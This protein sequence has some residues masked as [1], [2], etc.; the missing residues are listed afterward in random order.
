M[1][2]W[3]TPSFFK[4]TNN[5]YYIF[6]PE[7]SAK[8]AG[9]RALHYLCHALN[10]LGKEAYI[11]G[12]STESA[13]LRSPLLRESDVVRH[14]LMNLLP[15]MV[16]PEVVKDNPLQMPFVVRWLLNQAGHLGGDVEFDELE[17]LFTYSNSYISEGL[18]APL[19]NI[20]LVN[21]A[22]FNNEDNADDNNRQG[23]CYYAHKYLAKGYKLTEHVV[24]STSL[25]QD[26]DIS[27][28]EIANILRR[29]ELLY[30]YEPSAII[31]E[32][33]LCGC[34]VIMID[35]PFLDENL[36][37]PIKGKGL[38]STNIPNAISEAKKTIGEVTYNDK[39]SIN[40]CWWQVDRF[41]RQTQ[42]VAIDRQQNNRLLNHD[43]VPEV[44]DF[45]NHTNGDTFV[46]S[47]KRRNSN[48][49]RW[50]KQN[51]LLEGE[52]VI[53]AE[54]M[55]NNWQ[56]KPT[57]H[58]IMVINRHELG[59]LSDTL[60]SL[61]EQLYNAWGLTIFSN[62]PQ[63][64]VVKDIPEN[65][66]WIEITD[67]LNLAINQSVSENALDWILQL[68]PGDKLASHA[69]LSFAETIN[70]NAETRFIYSDEVADERSSRLLFKPDFNLELLCSSSYLG[71]SVII[72]RD[73]F[74]AI[75]GYTGLA[76][77]YVTD[78]AFNIYEVW[79]ANAIAHIADVLYIASSVDVDDEVL[80]DSE[81]SVRVAHFQRQKVAA[82]I[83]LLAGKNTFTVRYL[84]IQEPLVSIIVANKNHAS[85]IWQCIDE[86]LT[87]TDYPNYEL[88]IVD[89]HSDIEDMEF[90]YQDM[91]DE[92]GDR[93]TLLSYAEPN[94]AAMINFGVS[95]AKGDY[96]VI[97]ANSA[98]PVN[99][100]WLTTMHSLSQRP[101]VGV[102]GVR[103]IGA[104]NKVVHA[105]GVLGLTDDVQGL[106]FGEEF[107]EAGYMGRAQ[108]TQEYS[109]VSSACFMV[110]THDYKSVGGLDEGDLANT[111]YS[112]AD[113][114]LK[115][116]QQGR[117]T[118]WEPQAVFRQ[119]MDMA[120]E[121]NGV[122]GEYKI[123]VEAIVIKRWPDECQ[124]DV[125]Y[126]RNLSLR[127]FDF[128]ADTVINLGW[129]HQHMNRPRI[130]AFPF[131]QGAIGHYRVI[132]PLR[133]LTH[134]AMIESTLLP[135]HDASSDTFIPNRF[136]MNKSRP[137]VLFMHLTLND[138][139]YEFLKRIK[140]ET[141][142][143]VVF[144]IDDLV[145]SL[146]SKNA[147]K[148]KLHKDMRH[149]LGRTLALCDR[150]VASTQPLADALSLYC[151]D[152]KIIPNCIDLARWETIEAQPQ[153]SKKLRVG[154]A[155]GQYHSGDLDIISDVVKE[156][157]AE[158]D[159]IFMGMCPEELKPYIHEYH[160]FSSFHDYPE[161]LANLQLDLAVAPLEVHPFNE[162]KSN[163]R[164][165]EYGMLAWP[166]ICSDIYPY[167]TNN[168]PVTRIN[169]SSADWLDAIRAAIAHP[170]SLQREGQALRSWVLNNYVLEQHREKWLKALTTKV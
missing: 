96:V 160:D 32:A 51:I 77:V 107:D 137:D 22:L 83:A 158:I 73:A 75:G 121:S 138:E 119:N 30:C 2:Q 67:T 110:S 18:S 130:M 36:S 25:C 114:C 132:E 123:D 57:F 111:K 145:T 11:I 113:L 16:Y 19:L 3:H 151:E 101:E 17:L 58:L 21:G 143:F 129:A 136:E 134:A 93:F 70:Q 154:W 91:Q 139:F 37:S 152:I 141:T 97:L 142:I 10:E 55:L 88:V 127:T 125:F 62:I 133:E 135:S 109:F 60:N 5:P 41:I 94:Y 87:H 42:A 9:V 140:A 103:V 20:P 6:A 153:T 72:R 116:K 47:K 124:N 99:N 104:D 120:N 35:T 44:L 105:G 23:T 52:A 85:A 164:L 86:L 56:Q 115:L 144:S 15:I 146:P 48:D 147:S 12:C 1:L 169:N 163:L 49:K 98:M 8:S 162:S 4:T 31:G 80:S 43:W 102:V 90:I 53:M 74:Q 117:K 131:N 69:L 79:G 71:R 81:L 84:D 26:I 39:L 122:G 159:W 108:L 126:N 149:R 63:P 38:S 66:E 64:D 118:V 59:L 33:L 156:T 106:F 45:I 165:L 28:Q 148:K 24:D 161:K 157:A 166:V 34:P 128:Q 54:H 170:E 100:D 7:F 168:P 14:E 112:V 68:L 150:V 78:L 40:Y 76:Y 155:G 89:C 65:I 82:K 27:P 50:L 95:H 13:S 92:L 29:S 46:K 61:Q 167:Q